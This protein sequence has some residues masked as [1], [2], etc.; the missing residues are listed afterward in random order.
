MSLTLQTS[1]STFRFD[2]ASIHENGDLVDECVNG[3]PGIQKIQFDYS[4]FSITGVCFE[5]LAPVF[6]SAGACMLVSIVVAAK[7]WCPRM[8]IVFNL[9]L[10]CV[11]QGY[12]ECPLVHTNHRYILPDAYLRAPRFG[13]LSIL[14]FASTAASEVRQVSGS[15]RLRKLHLK[16][17]LH[18]FVLPSSKLSNRLFH[19]IHFYFAEQN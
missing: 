16:G 2:P 9:W 12:V 5:A 8:L 15:K 1:Q 3:N 19:L 11:H 10:I 7:P 4:N 13:E 18:L 17:L 6:A 14:L